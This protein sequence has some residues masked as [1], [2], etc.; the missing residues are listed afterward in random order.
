MS[1]IIETYR[2]AM[3]KRALQVEHDF[4]Q[5]RPSG[6]NGGYDAGEGFLRAAIAPTA[7]L[8]SEEL[9]LLLDCIAN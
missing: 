6:E 2:R 8:V 9:Q 1:L 7:I 5:R 3:A 4:M